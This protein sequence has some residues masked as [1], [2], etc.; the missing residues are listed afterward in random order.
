LCLELVEEEGVEVEG[1]AKEALAAGA[2]QVGDL[3]GVCP[4]EVRC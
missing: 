3:A 1:A 2:V 4:L